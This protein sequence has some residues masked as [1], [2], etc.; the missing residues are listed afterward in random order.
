M[1]ADRSKPSIFMELPEVAAPSITT[2]PL[3]LG[4]AS[5]IEESDQS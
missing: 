2:L 3:A 1:Y 5:Q 4:T